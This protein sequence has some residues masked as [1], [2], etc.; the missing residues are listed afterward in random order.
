M[1]RNFRVDETGILNPGVLRHHLE[2]YR[3][4]ADSQNTFGE[5]V[6]TR[7]KYA[8]A[9]GQIKNL[10]GRELEQAMQ[11]WAESRYEVTCHFFDG[12]SPKDEID[13][14]GGADVPG[15]TTLNILDASDVS[16]TRRILTIICRDYAV[17]QNG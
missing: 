15:G 5:D 13:V 17:T 10:Q 9:R 7:E 3:L 6:V 4:T 2:F 8:D 12:V 11:R 16:G 14:D 1:R